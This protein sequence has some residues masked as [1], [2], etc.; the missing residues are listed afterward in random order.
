MTLR[1]FTL[2]AIGLLTFVGC[3]KPEFAEFV[4][5]EHK[6]KAHFPGTPEYVVKTDPSDP[7][8]T[9]KGYGVEVGDVAYMVTFTLLSPEQR[10][11]DSETAETMLNRA[12]DVSAKK[13]GGVLKQETK[14]MLAGKYLGREWTLDFPPSK[15]TW[16]WRLFV[17][18]DRL[19]H[20][21]VIDE[22]SAIGSGDTQRFLDSFS[23]IE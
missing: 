7:W 12:R 14:I 22:G 5:H 10:N 8:A 13:Q 20:V 17:T 1:P 2:A 11:A 15:E 3:G 21:M 19:I 6:F 23:L 16:K 9:V 4:S 18:N